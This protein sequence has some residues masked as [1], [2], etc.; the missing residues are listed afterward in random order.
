MITTTDLR[1]ATCEVKGIK[2]D[3]NFRGVKGNDYYVLP[4]DADLDN[5]IK[6]KKNDIKFRIEGVENKYLK[7]C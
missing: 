7:F 6:V 5:P 3:C 4:I 2:I 1:N